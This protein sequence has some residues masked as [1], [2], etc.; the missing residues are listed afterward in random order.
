[1]EGSIEDQLQSALASARVHM[2][3]NQELEEK[4]RLQDELVLELRAV[5]RAN[6]ELDEKENVTKILPAPTELDSTVQGFKDEIARLK[7]ALEMTR[8]GTQ[9]AVRMLADQYEAR[10]ARLEEELGMTRE[11]AHLAVQTLADGYEARI[12]E[13]NEEIAQKG[14]Q[15]QDLYNYSIDAIKTLQKASDSDLAKM[16]AELAK[17][18]VAPSDSPCAAPGSRS[19]RAPHDNPVS[20]TL[21][22]KSPMPDLQIGLEI[23]TRE[24]ADIVDA[25]RFID[26][27]E[28]IGESREDV[29]NNFTD[30]AVN[31]L[32]RLKEEMMKFVQYTH[33]LASQNAREIQELTELYIKEVVCM[34]TYLDQYFS[35]RQ[36]FRQKARLFKHQL[37]ECQAELTNQK[38]DNQEI[39]LELLRMQKAMHPS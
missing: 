37:K 32:E 26:Y 36:N 8:E 34:E 28:L 29:V 9:I 4:L 23:I 22:E 14:S 12:A 3:I 30:E 19:E 11:G 31:F 16:R 24:L 18:D 39:R 1:M 15:Y 6:K 27:D 17:R 5:L 13:L 2:S 33:S 35:D 20:C 10:I 21:L 38:Q 7:E 25:Y